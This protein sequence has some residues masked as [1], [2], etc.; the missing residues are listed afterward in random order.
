LAFQAGRGIRRV[1]NVLIGY[2]KTNIKPSN[3]ES[4][5]MGFGYRLYPS[6]ALTGLDEQK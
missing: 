5:M 6:Y 4:I 3:K 1:G 2:K